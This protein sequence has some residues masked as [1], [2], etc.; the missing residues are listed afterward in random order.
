MDGTVDDTAHLRHQCHNSKCVLF[1]ERLLKVLEV[2]L[3][4]FEFEDD[5]TAVQQ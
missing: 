4:F 2:L 1:Q 5:T 3:I